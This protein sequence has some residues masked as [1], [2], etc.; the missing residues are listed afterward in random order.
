MNVHR[1]I[2]SDIRYVPRDVVNLLD[3]EL[4]DGL[5]GPYLAQY[6]HIID[7]LGLVIPHGN[8]TMRCL[9][10]DAYTVISPSAFLLDIPSGN[11]S[12]I[13]DPGNGNIRVVPGPSMILGGTF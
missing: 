3:L 12:L 5:C 13:S 7:L 10:H 4:R 2:A 6:V 8:C 11:A 9:T 1:C